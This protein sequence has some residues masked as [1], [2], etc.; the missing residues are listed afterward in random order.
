VP[1]S[2]GQQSACD[3]GGNLSLVQLHADHA[4]DPFAATLAG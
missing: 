1:I 2:L 4:D 3:H